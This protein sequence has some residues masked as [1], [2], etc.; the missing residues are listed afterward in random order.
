MRR[1]T[2][3][4]ILTAASALVGCASQ[5]P[6]T[7][8]GPATGQ[9]AAA[10]SGGTASAQGSSATASATGQN[11]KF[12][13]PAGWRRVVRDGNELYCGKQDTAGSRVQ[14][15]EVC[16]TKDQL[17]QMQTASQQYLDNVE[18]ADSAR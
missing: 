5:A 1:V 2:S 18:R 16:L 10:T 3:F 4:V 6:A 15:R 17:Q 7:S 9:A 8:S 14:A 13:V 11:D 12:V